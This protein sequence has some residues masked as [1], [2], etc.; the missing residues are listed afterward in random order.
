[1]PDTFSTM[2]HKCATNSTTLIDVPLDQLQIPSR[3]L[4]KHPKSQIEKLK[5]SLETYG[6]VSPILIEQHNKL[7]AGVAR[8]RAAQELGLTHARALRI[9][10]LSNAEIRA[11]RI[12]DNKLAEAATWNEELLSI[13]LGEIELLGFDL[14]LT[15]FET[16]EIDILFSNDGAD[17]GLTDHVEAPDQDQVAI[18]RLG[19]L[20]E[21]GAHRLYCG[22]ALDVESYSA[23]FGDEQADMVFTDPP[24]NVPVKGH[25]GGT[26]D[27]QHRE[28]VMASGEMSDVEFRNFLTKTMEKAKARTRPGGVIFACMDW[29][30]IATLID[31][32]NASGLELIN[33]CV[34]NKANGGMGSLYRSK[35]ELII[36]A[37]TPGASH[38][39]NVELGR[40]GRNRTNVW[41]YPGA[42]QSPDLKL[43]P[44]VKPIALVAD[45]IQDVTHRGDI[46]LDMFGG[47]GSTMMAAERTGRQ[48]RLIELDPLYVD[49][50]IR[51]FEKEFGAGA[52]LSSTGQSFTDV[53]AERS[54]SGDQAVPA[55]RVRTRVRPSTAKEV[56]HAH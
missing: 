54:A 36:V 19:D 35:H 48:A 30:S 31:V 15:G 25:M 53:E 22:D 17:E 13:E 37:R 32:T 43:H 2:R 29:R 4:R 38:T 6:W 49:T 39:N 5:Q 42:G 47:S 52:I 34:W 46:V 41:D 44:T 14:E 45:A 7:I 50:A 51:R 21:I 20:W 10:H 18:S 55:V 27:I 16:P 12:A 23:L 24:Y 56:C 1:M 8:V 26:G 28:F 9:E 40:H 33:L 11:Y 3:E